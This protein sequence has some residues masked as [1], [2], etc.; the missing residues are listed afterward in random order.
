MSNFHNA[1]YIQIRANSTTDFLEVPS[2]LPIPRPKKQQCHLF[3]ARC[4]RKCEQR[5]KE[6]SA[7][8]VKVITQRPS[9]LLEEEL[10]GV[11][12]NHDA[13]PGA[14]IAGELSDFENESELEY[15]DEEYLSEDDLELDSEEAN[16]LILST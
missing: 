11:Q 8:A 13:D 16:R 5:V 1:S 3:G 2:L 6:L 9:Q 10:V 15:I 4:L 7:S 12:D 14:E